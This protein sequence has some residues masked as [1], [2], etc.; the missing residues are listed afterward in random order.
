MSATGLVIHFRSIVGVVSMFLLISDVEP[1]SAAY[2]PV[3]CPQ[4]EREEG[5]VASCRLFLEEPALRR[6]GVCV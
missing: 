5:L 1:Y 6:L 2:V 4:G 3:A